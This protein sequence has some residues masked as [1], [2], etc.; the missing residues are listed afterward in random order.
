MIC[1]F[2]GMC[3][4]F[5]AFARGAEKS[6]LAWAFCLG[7]YA[8]CDRYKSLFACCGARDRRIG[9]AASERTTKPDRQEQDLPDRPHRDRPYKDQ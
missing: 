4:G 7:E 6:H 5:E 1:P 2:A 3:S 8:D 9:P